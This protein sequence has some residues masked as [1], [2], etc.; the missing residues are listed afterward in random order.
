[1]AFQRFADLAIP[2]DCIYNDFLEVFD[3]VS[4]PILLQ[5]YAAYK[6]GIKTLAFIADYLNGRTQ[7][8]VVREAMSSSIDVLSRVPRVAAWVQFYFVYLSMIC[9]PLFRILLSRCLQM[10]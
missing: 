4:I 3:K 10:M 9:R 8:A 5:R 1:M 6:L 7:Q 2:F